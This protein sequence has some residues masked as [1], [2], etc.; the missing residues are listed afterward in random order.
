[1][2]RFRESAVWSLVLTSHSYAGIATHYIHSSSLPQLEARL[3]EIVFKDYATQAERYAIIDSTIEEFCTGLPSPRPT[4]SGDLRRAVD[5]CFAAEN[6][7]PSDILNAL[8]AVETQSQ[9]QGIKEWAARTQKT[10]KERSPTS[11]AVTLRQM[12]TSRSWDIAQTFQHEHN[13]AST[14]MEHHDFIEGVTARLIERKKGRPDWKPNTLQEVTSADVDSFFDQPL[15]LALLNDGQG[16]RYKEYPHAEIGL[17]TEE[18]ILQVWGQSRQATK[19][20]I[21]QRFIE[22][23]KGK[24]GVKEKVEEVLQRATEEAR[25]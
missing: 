8:S 3:A 10:M 16:S 24:Q 19:E 17:P 18:Q 21:V 1:M 13:I 4:I 5:V 6:S 2:S 25:A 9:D 12:Q 15:E 20:D 14:F 23:K 22:A 11:V 7:T